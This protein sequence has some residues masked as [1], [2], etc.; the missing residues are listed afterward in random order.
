MHVLFE[1]FLKSGT[2]G[3][4]L[5]T[6]ETLADTQAQ[7]MTPEDAKAVGIEGIPDDPEGRLR[8]LIVVSKSDER[9]IYNQL[10]LSG[11]V[12]AFRVHEVAL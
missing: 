4:G 11:D 2:S 9:R 12:T 3:E 8:L 7:I 5:L 1:V 6:D 10:E